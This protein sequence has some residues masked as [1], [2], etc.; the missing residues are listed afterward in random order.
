MKK[1]LMSMASAVLALGLTTSCSEE[2]PNVANYE[3]TFAVEMEGEQA[4]RAY[5]DGKSAKQLIFAVYEAGTEKELTE[6]RKEDV[7]FNEELKAKVTT[8]LVKGKKYDFVFWAQPIGA[9][10][11]SVPQNARRIEIDYKNAKSNDEMRDA[12][13]TVMNN[14]HAGKNAT[15]TV[16]IL[17]R[18]F[19]QI[20]FATA[21]W[22]QAVSAGVGTIQTAVTIKNVFTQLNTLTGK[23][24]GEI[25]DV[26]VVFD[27]APIPTAEND[28][29]YCNMDGDDYPEAYRWL[30]MNYV[31]VNDGEPV[32]GGGNTS[33]MVTL[34]IKGTAENGDVLVDNTVEVPN[35]PMQRNWRTNIVGKLLTTDAQ[36]NVQIKPEPINDYNGN[37]DTWK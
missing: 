15:D 21:D 22:A 8:T 23:S 1:V 35:V 3:V 19:A 32:K 37:P 20:N 27:F 30:A 10:T 31:L 6:L 29:L 11:F 5:N 24:E 33:N 18:P 16:F 36:F 17:T 14:Y 4:S 28:T 26:P 13:Y 7:T 12:F 9:T 2:T 34:K 25:A